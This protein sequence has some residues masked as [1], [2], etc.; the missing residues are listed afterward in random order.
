MHDFTA[1][2]DIRQNTY[3][4]G[5][6]VAMFTGGISPGTTVNGVKIRAYVGNITPDED[7]T[8]K[9][10]YASLIIDTNTVSYDTDM[11]WW[12]T[13]YNHTLAGKTLTLVFDITDSNRGKYTFYL[14]RVIVRNTK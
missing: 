4:R 13:K 10:D 2:I 11:V 14:Y 6:Y 12:Y 9:M 1:D 3:K 7:L 8:A 5:P